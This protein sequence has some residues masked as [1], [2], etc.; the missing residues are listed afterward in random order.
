M[1]PRQMYWNPL[2]YASPHCNPS[3]MLLDR[4]QDD[5][6]QWVDQWVDCD[7][8]EF[9]TDYEQ[10]VDFRPQEFEHDSDQAV[11]RL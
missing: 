8:Q 2:A 10:S 11:G 7:P 1:D 4:D 5:E 9:E 6:D 3:A